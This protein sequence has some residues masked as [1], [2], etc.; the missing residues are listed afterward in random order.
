MFGCG[1]STK[2]SVIE[3]EK[4]KW[5]EEG[6]TFLETF[7]RECSNP[8]VVVDTSSQT[9]LEFTAF[10]RS[11]EKTESKIYSQSES[12]FLVVSMQCHSGD[13]FS[14]VFTKTKQ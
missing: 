6:W 9:A 5:E 14:L 1:G 3:R 12:L 11:D 10:S 4:E 7:G 13:Q 2:L 8:I